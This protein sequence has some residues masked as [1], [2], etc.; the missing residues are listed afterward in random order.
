M[1]AVNNGCGL[2]QA[3]CGYRPCMRGDCG[4]ACDDDC[5]PT[6]GPMRRA[7]RPCAPR[8]GVCADCD[9]T[10]D[11]SCGRPCRAPV[12]Q[13]CASCRTSGQCG[14]CSTCGDCGGDPCA[15]PCGSGCYGRPW[16]RGPLS[17]VFALF[18]PCTWCGPSCGER[19]WGDFYGNPHAYGDPCDCQGNYAGC[20]GGGCRNCGGRYG[21]TTQ[22]GYGP[23]DQGSG[24]A[25]DGVPEGNIISQTDRAVGQPTGPAPQPHKAAKPQPQ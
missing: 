24:R 5:G 6:C 22:M 1:L 7:A 16:H 14:G 13:G 8:A 4:M 9:A 17:C 23:G 11:T 2:F 15:D 18:M 25:D 12:C 3:C 20:N 10:C 19:Y 21:Q